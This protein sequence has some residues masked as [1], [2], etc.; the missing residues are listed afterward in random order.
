M[1]FASLGSGSEGNALVVAAGTTRIMIDCGFP[2]EE[3]ERRLARIGLAP[4]DIAAIV[5]THE[6]GDHSDGCLPFARRHGARVWMT[7]GTACALQADGYAP[8]GTTL[9]LFPDA[10]PAQVVAFDS[11]TPFAI[12]DLEVRPFPVPH[13]AREPVQLVITDGAVRLG[14]L[15]DTGTPTRHIEAMLS[16]CD[17]LFLECNHDPQMLADGPYPGWLKSRIA[18]PFGHLANEAAGRLLSTIDRTKLRDVI[19]AHLSR[20]NN[21]PRLATAAL[22]TALGCAQDDI[23]VADQKDGIGWRSLK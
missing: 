8:P 10:P 4:A 21:I 23:G 15:T 17:G 5:V 12:G 20:T 6:H 19:A 2:V 7:Y 3:T 13:D 18:G 11:H 9:P 22:A 16:G 14:V 1:R